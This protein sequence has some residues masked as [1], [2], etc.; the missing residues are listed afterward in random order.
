HQPASR[1]A[2]IVA[3]GPIANFLLAILVFAAVF[4]TFG[5]QIT[6]ARVDSV[7]ADSAAAAAGFQ[8]GDRVVGIGG[9]P[10][11]SFTDMQRIVGASAGRTLDITV[12]RGGVRTTLK[13]V[14]APRAGKDRRG[15][16]ER[17]SV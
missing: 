9:R 7:Q 14:P 3:A 11:E 6:S 1:R 12:D 15:T 2:A 5:K 10:I 8:A 4:M 13:A 17:I 16:A